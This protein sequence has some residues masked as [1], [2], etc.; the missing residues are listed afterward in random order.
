MSELIRSV[1]VMRTS[2]ARAH[3]LLR[4]SDLVACEEPLELQIDGQSLAVVMRTPGHD[5]EL[6]TGFLLTEGI[7]KSVDE[8]VTLRHCTTVPSPEAEDNVMQIRLAKPFD[9]SRMKRHF[10]ATSSCGVC[11]KATIENALRVSRPVTSNTT[12]ARDVL[13][14]LP[15]KLR[16]GQVAFE[17]TGGLHAA[18]LFDQRGQLHVLRED[19][20]R[21]NAVDKV[22]GWSMR[23]D[24]S[25]SILMVSGRL[26]FE[27]VQKCVAARIPVLAGI[28]APTSLA[29]E[30]A[31]ALGVT[32]IGFLRGGSMNGYSH[33]ERIA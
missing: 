23:A 5:E 27:L 30:M 13:A 12:I 8:L 19:V 32:L 21:H 24:V 3:Q 25:A 7:I 11:G 29:V 10:F 18:A 20:G 4:E 16:A 33:S 6:A 14:S 22:I 28:S 2:G 26:S 9:F 15:E 17:Q 31:D 1:E